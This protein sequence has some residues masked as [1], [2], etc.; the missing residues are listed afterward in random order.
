[1]CSASTAETTLEANQFEQVDPAVEVD[2]YD[3]YHSQK[4]R[5]NG[6]QDD[7]GGYYEEDC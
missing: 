7:A 5:H 1:M 4:G 6:T 2:R 3:A